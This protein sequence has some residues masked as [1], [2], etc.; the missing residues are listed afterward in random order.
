M[1]PRTKQSQDSFIKSMR[2]VE[3]VDMCKVMNT[4]SPT[5]TDCLYTDLAVLCAHCD[6]LF[7]SS[8]R[9]IPGHAGV[10]EMHIALKTTIVIAQW[11]NREWKRMRKRERGGESERER[12]GESRHE[13]ASKLLWLKMTRLSRQ[14]YV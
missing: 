6:I 8:F 10:L 2:I 14:T 9:S 3:V 5:C 1:K 11:K 13:A 4:R 12:E 7:Y